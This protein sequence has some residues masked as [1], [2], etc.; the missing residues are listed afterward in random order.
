MD[1]SMFQTAEY[2]LQFSS[3]Y[4]NSILLSQCQQRPSELKIAR[5]Y[6]HKLQSHKPLNRS[7]TCT[8]GISLF[9]S[10]R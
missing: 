8:H 3:M 4:C 10:L 2:F 6:S 1:L 9:S 7:Y 5:V